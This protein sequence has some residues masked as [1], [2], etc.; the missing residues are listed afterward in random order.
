ML[1]TV[2][3]ALVSLWT[4]SAYAQT[5]KLEPPPYQPLP[6]GTTIWYDRQTATVME[7]EGL[8]MVLKL[9][10]GSDWMSLYGMFQRKGEW[11]YKT[12]SNEPFITQFGGDAVEP[13]NLYSPMKVGTTV[14]VDIEK[15]HE[16]SGL[17]RAWKFNLTV[18]STAFVTVGARATR[19]RSSP[20]QARVRPSRLVA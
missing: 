2:V 5:S 3:A 1:N 15:F 9:N 6:V 13:P 4:I 19:P 18:E 16:W 14:S 10:S 17:S 11:Q 12:S 7:T 20:K 8:E